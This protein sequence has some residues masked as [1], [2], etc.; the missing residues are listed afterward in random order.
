VR[1]AGAVA[2][3]H[4]DSA[5]TGA[6]SHS[7]TK[8]TYRLL[9]MPRFAQNSL[10]RAG[11]GQL[12][13]NIRPVPEPPPAPRGLMSV[14]MPIVAARVSYFEAGL[15]V[16]ADLGFGGLKLA[17]VCSRLGVTSG[18]FYHYFPGW[19]AYTR[20]LLNY[21]MHDRTLRLGEVFRRESDPRRRMQLIVR[22]VLSL[23]HS[24]EAAIRAWASVDPGV[25]AVQAEVDR[26]RFSV[27]YEYAFEI[28]H[29]QRQAEVFAQWAVYQL[30]GFEQATLERDGRD[31][32]W[33]INRMLDDLEAGRFASVPRR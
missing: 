15:E 31:Y 1:P 10:A 29:D 5:V 3:A 14:S 22:E 26:E 20:E 30:V 4:D 24:A 12:G 25:L 33:M 13:P 21:W 27:C 7:R 8:P 16:L 28:V 19:S 9:K 32:E 2:S 17:E 23:P 11:M 18:S 6:G